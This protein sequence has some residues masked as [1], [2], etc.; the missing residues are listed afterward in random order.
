MQTNE[1]FSTPKFP[2]ATKSLHAELKRRVNE[3]LEQHEIK[4]TGNFKLFSKAIILIGLFLITYVHLVFFTPSTLFAILEC[5]FF[6]CLIAAIGFNVMHD[7]SHGSFSK[8]AWLNKLASS[9]I[10]VLGA[11]RFMWGMKHV[12]IHHTYTNS[13]G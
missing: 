9:S 10:S 5:A 6:G 13:D 11:S 12:T 8:Y 1:T 7:G 2:V 4:A 3:Y